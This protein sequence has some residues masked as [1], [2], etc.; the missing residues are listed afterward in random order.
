MKHRRSR[1]GSMSNEKPRDPNAM[2]VT[3]TYLQSRE[4]QESADVPIEC[5]KNKSEPRAEMIKMIKPEPAS[6][7]EPKDTNY[8]SQ[9]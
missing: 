6:T 5:E 8:L 2:S 9:R 3:E 4:L 7:N 1:V